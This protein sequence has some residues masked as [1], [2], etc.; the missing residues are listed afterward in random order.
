M[1]KI[2]GLIR[3]QTTNKS[4]EWNEIYS[5][6][7]FQFVWFVWFNP[8]FVS[9]CFNIWSNSFDLF[10]YW[11]NSFDLFQYLVWF[12]WFVSIFGLIRLI[13]LICITQNSKTHMLR[14]ECIYK[15][16]RARKSLYL[17][18]KRVCESV[19]KQCDQIEIFLYHL[20]EYL[21]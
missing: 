3:F 16:N 12:V 1:H 8:I 9:I 15:K 17:S 10:Q 6:Y 18:V 20:I 5:F 21:G 2:F 11:S 14:S 4:N 7:S 13:R 19:E